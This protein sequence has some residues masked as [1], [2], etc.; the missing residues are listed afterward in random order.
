MSS[1]YIERRTFPFDIHQHCYSHHAQEHTQPFPPR[2]AW[3][4][5]NNNVRGGTNLRRAKARAARET[6]KPTEELANDWI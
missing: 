1:Q 5:I 2:Y 6:T 4:A 3:S